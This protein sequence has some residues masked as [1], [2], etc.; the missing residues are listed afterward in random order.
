MPAECAGLNQQQPPGFYTQ[1]LLYNINV[2]LFYRR[3][4]KACGATT[5]SETGSYKKSVERY[6]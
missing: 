5:Q 4:Q 1:R 6:R 2:L 3:L